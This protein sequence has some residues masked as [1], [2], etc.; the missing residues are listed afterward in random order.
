MLENGA[1]ASGTGG[2]MMVQLLGNVSTIACIIP[3]N[4]HQVRVF[5]PERTD[6]L[7]AYHLPD[8]HLELEGSTIL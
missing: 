1:S 2:N 7:I 6:T 5:H 4:P 3:A 8:T